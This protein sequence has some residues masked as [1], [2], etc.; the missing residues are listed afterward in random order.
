MYTLIHLW[1]IVR[2]F[3]LMS[4]YSISPFC[5]MTFGTCEGVTGFFGSVGVFG[6]S[7]ESDCEKTKTRKGLAL[8]DTEML[9]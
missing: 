6:E 8:E 9:F 4:I 2:D 5:L 7:I 3:Q 1:Q